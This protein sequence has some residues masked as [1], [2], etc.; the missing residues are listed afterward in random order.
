MQALPTV[1]QGRTSKGDL[2]GVTGV[3]WTLSSPSTSVDEDRRTRRGGNV[4][5]RTIYFA[6]HMQIIIGTATFLYLD[7]FTRR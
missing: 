3:R 2:G 7:P 1:L 5:L 6:Y 4:T